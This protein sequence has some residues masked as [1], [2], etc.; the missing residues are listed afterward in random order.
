MGLRQSRRGWEARGGIW[1]GW[2]W[3]GREWGMGIR[4]SRRGWEARGGPDPSSKGHGIINY[5]SM[6]WMVKSVYL[7][8]SRSAVLFKPAD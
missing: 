6:G 1:G 8:S 4:Q 7:V 2:G 3:G 5:F